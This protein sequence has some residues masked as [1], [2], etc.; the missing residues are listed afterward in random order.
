MRAPLT[1]HTLFSP[2]PL[3]QSRDMFILTALSCALIAAIVTPSAP[4]RT[5]S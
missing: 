2:K 5:T 4:L 3:S 1:T